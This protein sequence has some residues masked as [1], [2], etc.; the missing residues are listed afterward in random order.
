MNQS[1]QQLSLLE[2]FLLNQEEEDLK[3]PVRVELEGYEK[4][5]MMKSWFGIEDLDTHFYRS[6]PQVG[7]PYDM[8]VHHT[9][10][11]LTFKIDEFQSYIGAGLIR[12]LTE[13]T[14]SHRLMFERESILGELGQRMNDLGRIS[15]NKTRTD[16]DLNKELVLLDKTLNDLDHLLMEL[17]YEIGHPQTEDYLWGELIEF[18]GMKAMIEKGF[19]E[20]FEEGRTDVSLVYRLLDISDHPRYSHDLRHQDYLSIEKGETTRASLATRYYN[21]LKGAGPFLT[22]VEREEE[23]INLLKNAILKSNRVVVSSSFGKDSIVILHL[24][25]RTCDLLNIPR[26][27]IDVFYSDTLNEFNEVRKVADFYQKREGFNLI[28]VNPKKSLKRIIE[29]HGGIDESYFSRKGDRRKDSEGQTLQPLSE[30]CC[31]TLKHQP[32]YEAVER[33]QW[34]L[35]VVGTR[36]DESHQRRQAG[37]RDGEYLYWKTGGLFKVQPIL[38]WTDEEVFTYIEKYQLRLPALY[39]QNLILDTPKKKRKKDADLPIQE[40][41]TSMGIGVDGVVKKPLDALLLKKLGF[42][43]YTPRVGCLLCPTPIKHGYLRWLREF[44]PKV[45]NGMLS[46][47]GYAAPLIKLIPKQKREELELMLGHKLTTLSLME[48]PEWIEDILT[49]MPCAFDQLT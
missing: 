26:H 22:L 20:V 33:Y 32:F 17:E 43:V 47:M 8:S 37:I 40:L 4:D 41:Y 39:S 10:K 21:D 36:T 24:V 12:C 18:K 35:N 19:Y 7:S 6:T 25:L 23:A 34:D 45:F 28:K 5:G 48:H 38:H 29:E 15:K 16:F 27:K 13:L 42:K 49:Y 9:H 11:Y 31:E 1:A 44:Y 3:E 46:R 14:T 2:A 30:K